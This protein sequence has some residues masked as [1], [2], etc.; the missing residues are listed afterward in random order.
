MHS[1]WRGGAAAML[2][3]I[4][5]ALVLTALFLPDVFEP[6]TLPLPAPAAQTGAV[7]RPSLPKKLRIPSLHIDVPVQEVGLTPQ[8]NMGIPSGAW[9]VGWYRPG[10]R[11]GEKGN[12]VMAGHLDTLF[13]PAVF[14]HLDQARPGDEI[15]VDSD[16]GSVLRFIVTRSDVYDAR[17]APMREIF[18]GGTGRM[19]RLI[20]CDGAWIAERRQYS[21]RLVVSAELREKE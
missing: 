21:E 1:S 14:E 13:G 12:A 5:T 15:L 4:A 20:T 11:P 8:G 17:S 3:G 18:G 7:M 6:A 19:L 10:F 9:E 2:S 16:S